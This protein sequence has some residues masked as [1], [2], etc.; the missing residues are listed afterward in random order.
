M[1][2]LRRPRLLS[3]VRSALD[4]SPIVTLSGPRQCGKTTLAR[5][6]AEERG[7]TFFDIENPADARRL[8]QPM[9]TLAP[10]HGLVVIDEAQLRP[11]I[12]PILRV[13]ADRRPNPA[14]FLLLGSASPDLIRGASE[15]L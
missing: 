7:G 3:A 12:A 9:S 11:E 2:D 5:M 13:L 8:E 10:L 15:S 4:R 6:V 1:D 14:S